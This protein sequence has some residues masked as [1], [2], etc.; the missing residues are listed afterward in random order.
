MIIYDVNI[1][2]GISRV[3]VE[4]IPYHVTQRGNRRED[5]FFDDESRKRYLERLCEYL[6]KHGFEDMGILF[7]D[8]SCPLDCSSRGQ[9]FFRKGATALTHAVCAIHK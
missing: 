4:G 5:V 6:R 7:N 8:E 2:P 1:M 3:I 9:E